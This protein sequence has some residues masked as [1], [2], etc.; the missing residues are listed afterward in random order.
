MQ[1]LPEGERFGNYQLTGLIGV[2]GMG[3]VYRAVHPEIGRV[4]AIKVLRNELARDEAAV[5]RFFDEARAVNA[6]RHEGIVDIF[7]LGRR[8]DGTA[9]YVMEYLAGEDLAHLLKREGRVP[10][11]RACELVRQVLGALGA[12]HRRGIVHRDLKPQ[13]LFAIPRGFETRVKILDFGIAK[14]LNEASQHPQTSTGVVLGTVHYM[15]PEQAQGEAI[16]ARA[17]LYSVG[18]ILYQ[19]VTGLVP[20]G[21]SNVMTVL[22]RLATQPLVPP[23][24]RA[25]DL[26]LPKAFD[27]AVVRALAKSRDDRFSDAEE[28]SAALAAIDWSTTPPRPRRVTPAPSGELVPV[29]GDTMPQPKAGSGPASKPEAEPESAPDAKKQTK[30]KPD[31]DS[32]RTTGKAAAGGAAA[33]R[34]PHP[35]TDSAGILREPAPLLLDAESERR[36]VRVVLPLEIAL[37]GLGLVLYWLPPGTTAVDH[38]TLGRWLFPFGLATF[39]LAV[40]TALFIATQGNPAG[41]W[42]VNRG[43]SILA[44]AIITIATSLT[45]ALTSYDILYYPLLVIIDRLREGRSL[46]RV[47][48]CLSLIAFVPVALLTHFGVIPYA[49]LYPG[50][51]DP[52]MVQDRGLLALVILVVSGTTYL[53]YLLVDH[54][55]ARVQRRERELRELGLGLA[56]RVEEQVELLRR[57]DD[58]RRFVEPTLADAVLRGD[59]AAFGHQRRRVT[60]VRLDCPAIARAAEDIDPEEFAGVLNELFSNVADLAA[61]HRGTVD[62]FAGG[63]ITVLFGAL[64]SD[65]PSADARDAVRFA[66]AA[67]PKVAQLG[68]RCEV[69]GVEDP[70]RAR[71]AVHTGFATVGSFG[72]PS[73][74]EF[75]AVGPI[76]EAAAA[77]LT[78]A[79]EGAVLTTHASVVLLQDAVEVAP[80]GERPLPG[81]RHAV[82]IYKI[83]KLNDAS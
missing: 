24:E 51:F 54:L 43:M 34:E 81:A 21:G 58:L 23:S 42:L 46:A 82:R 77:V 69:A 14:L 28:L 67:L 47:S 3:A 20:Y 22:A 17:D 31:S 44:V 18:C 30:R 72:S 7:D 11:Q 6:I 60:I 50:R 10:P 76:I 15:S 37:F 29:D 48:L 36:I 9:Y 16:D 75:T 8:D 73:R 65:G 52:R 39:S 49:P 19:L 66:L 56:G 12:A 71:A 53:S 70:P 25:A 27:E 57:S 33:A 78:Q 4:V 38:A 2:G 26:G 83:D 63:E 32:G 64:R 5:A 45:G 74:L 80:A 61:G 40:L 13:N 55:A 35:L 68:P 59:A 79:D 62:R 41:R 1:P